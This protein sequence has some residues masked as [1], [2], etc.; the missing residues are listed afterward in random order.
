MRWTLKKDPNEEVVYKLSKE[1]S[2]DK[3]L[4][5]LLA[6]RGIST[7]GE[8]KKFFRTSLC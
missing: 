6:Q 2:V 4:A 7:F 8:A 5:K 3:V 1:L